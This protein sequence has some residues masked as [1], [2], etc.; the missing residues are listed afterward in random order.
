[1]IDVTD[2]LMGEWDKEHQLIKIEYDALND[3]GIQRHLF[4]DAL[5]VRPKQS[6]L[7]DLIPGDNTFDVAFRVWR[8]HRK[9]LERLLNDFW[10]G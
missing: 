4:Y 10:L 5:I 3:I 6:V 7:L 9:K 1:M 8:I 2:S